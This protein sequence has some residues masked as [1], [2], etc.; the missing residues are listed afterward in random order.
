MNSNEEPCM[1]LVELSHTLAWRDRHQ[2]P[3]YP[4]LMLL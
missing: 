4:N 2:R 3:K 1:T